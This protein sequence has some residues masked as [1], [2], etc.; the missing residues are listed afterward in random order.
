MEVEAK[1]V[2]QAM[3]RKSSPGPDGF[4]PGFNT[5]AWP[6]VA[7]AVINFTMEFH[8]G[9]ADLEQLNRSYIVMLPKHAAACR[10]SDYRP[11]CL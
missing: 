9:A 3:N 7:G 6:A 8:H 4:G 11:I 1:A 5:A 10:P 2:V